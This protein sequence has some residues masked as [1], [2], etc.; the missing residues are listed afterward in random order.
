MLGM[1][2]RFLFERLDMFGWFGGGREKKLN[3]Q[4]AMLQKKALRTQRDGNLRVYADVVAEIEDLYLKL[5]ALQKPT[6]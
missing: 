2:S 1:V 3:K 5:D 6:D 4:I